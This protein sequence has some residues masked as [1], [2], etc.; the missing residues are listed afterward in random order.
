[1][2]KHYGKCALCRKSTELTF[3]HIPPRAAFNSKGIKSYIGED[4][5]TNDTMPWDVNNLPYKNMQRGVGDYSLCESCNNLTGTWYGNSYIG[6]A[7]ACAELL[8]KIDNNDAKYE[9]SLYNA[10]PLFFMK[11]IVSMFCSINN[12]NDE[13]FNQLREF[14]LNK[15][16]RHI[17]SS[18]YKICMYLTKG[19]FSRICPLSAV[20]QKNKNGKSEAI[21][22]TEICAPPL[23]FI[24]YFNPTEAWDYKG[25][26]ITMLSDC[27]DN[28]YDLQLPVE[29]K[30]INS[31]I[32]TD[33]RSKSEIIQCVEDNK[34]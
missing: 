3:E 16:S 23:G 8:S 28:K 20:L 9:I 14:V 25:T 11:Q 18:K 33:F 26:D 7:H 19:S 12:F 10:N 29:I 15:E 31:V 34:K 4:I 30:E 6:I 13:R 2:S 5:L 1:M 24:L 27:T 17:D 22:M 21:A 32:P